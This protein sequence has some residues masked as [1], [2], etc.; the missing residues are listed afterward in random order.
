MNG[1]VARK[2]RKYSKRAWKKYWNEM[3]DLSF[4]NRLQLCFDLMR[5]YKWL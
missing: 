1:R 5:K 3:C 2:L 4:I